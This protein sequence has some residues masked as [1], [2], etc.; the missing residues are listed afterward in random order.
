MNIFEK[1]WEIHG[2]RLMK[3]ELLL[4]CRSNCMVGLSYTVIQT[5]HIYINLKTFGEL[6]YKQFYR[7]NYFKLGKQRSTLSLITFRSL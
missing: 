3:D 1:I 2:R 5:C 7:L 4:C 6:F